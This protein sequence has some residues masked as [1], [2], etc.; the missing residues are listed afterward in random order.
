MIGTPLITSRRN[1]VSFF[2]VEVSEW[3]HPAF[4]KANDN[5]CPHCGG[6]LLPGDKASDCSRA[7]PMTLRPERGAC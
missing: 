7:Q 4:A 2:A 6:V 1:V 5:V 3:D